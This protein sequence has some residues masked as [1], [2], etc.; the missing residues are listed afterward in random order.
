M[1]S[2]KQRTNGLQKKFNNAFRFQQKTQLQKI[3]IPL[4]INA[5]I[6]HLRLLSE[7]NQTVCHHRPLLD[8]QPQ[9]QPK[10][11]NNVYPEQPFDNSN[12]NEQKQY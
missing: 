8:S 3:T 6:M 5:R 7:L 4:E 9:Q 2:N 1:K 10:K 12:A 11:N